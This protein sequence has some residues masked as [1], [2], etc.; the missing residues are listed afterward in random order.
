MTLKWLEHSHMAL[1]VGSLWYCKLVYW[2]AAEVCYVLPC[3]EGPGLQALWK[4][5]KGVTFM[6]ESAGVFCLCQALMGYGLFRTDSL[7]EQAHFVTGIFVGCTVCAALLSLSMIWVWGAEWNLLGDLTLLNP[8]NAI[9][10]ESGRHMIVNKPL[11]NVFRK[12]FYL[13]GCMCLLQSFVVVYIL[14][15]R[16]SLTQQ[17]RLLGGVLSDTTGELT[18]LQYRN[19]EHTTTAAGSTSSTTSSGT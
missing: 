16:R 9:F 1:L 19:A 7:G 18:P 6:G 15:E 10:E 17:F 3:Y 11:I 4:V 13:S 5:N 2:D 8:N 14:M 12:L